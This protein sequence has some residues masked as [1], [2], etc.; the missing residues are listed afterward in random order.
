MRTYETLVEDYYNLR[1]RSMATMKRPPTEEMLTALS[2]RAI[3]EAKTFKAQD[4]SNLMWGL[5][6]LS[7]EAS[8]DLLCGLEARIAEVA[9]SFITQHLANTMWSIAQ[10]CVYVYVCV[11]ICVCF[12]VCA[13]VRVCVNVCSWV[14]KVEDS[15][16][17]QHLANTMWSIVQVCV[18]VSLSASMTVFASVSVSEPV[19]VSI[20]SRACICVWW[21]DYFLTQHLARMQCGQ[22]RRWESTRQCETN[23]SPRTQKQ[24]P[25]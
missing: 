20:S 7:L 12:D 16:I 13:C 1:I 17:T 2:K 9:D 14:A 19:S 25:L 8:S 5:A 4:V 24:W 21:K 11:Y 10:V 22:S 23:W 3:S 15:F 18:C 6:T